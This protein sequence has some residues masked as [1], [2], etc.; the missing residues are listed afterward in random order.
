MAKKTS[1]AADAAAGLSFDLDTTNLREVVAAVKDF[2]PALA[3]QLRKQLRAVGDDI[4]ADQRSILNGPLPGSIAV[5]GK[6]T[7]LVVPKDGSKP[8]LR[9]VNVYEERARAARDRNRG[10]RKK[11]GQGLKTRVVTGKT[12]QGV[13]VRTDRRIGGEMSQVWQAKVF[14]HQAFGREPWIHQRGQ[15]YFWGPAVEGREAAAK[16]IDDAIAEAI[17]E[18]TKGGA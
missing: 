8:Y 16:K 15:Q 2:S 12:R 14:R 13:S 7:R 1:A 4:I 10:M 6:K 18:M 3:R 9:K 17:N 5:V 11:I